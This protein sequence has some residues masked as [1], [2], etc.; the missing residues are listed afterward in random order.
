MSFK[1]YR[2]DKHLEAEEF[3]D[4]VS[5]ALFEIGLPIGCYSSKKYQYKKGE[6]RAGVE[7]KYDQRVAETGNLYI[8]TAEKADPSRPAFSDSGIFRNDNSWLYVIG[9]YRTIW[10]F[11]KSMLRLLYEAT[12]QE[13]VPRYPRVDEATFGTSKGFLLPRI[14]A[15]RYAARVLMPSGETKATYAD[16]SNGTTT[17]PTPEEIVSGDFNGAYVKPWNRPLEDWPQHS[18]SNKPTDL[19]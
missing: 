16:S 7:I 5:D 13:G 17:G 18:Q 6:S 10:I 12:K 19:F 9:D 4:F 2:S 8:E 11:A 15:D 14:D 1:D 3:Q